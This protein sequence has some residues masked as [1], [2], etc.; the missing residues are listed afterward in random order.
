MLNSVKWNSIELRNKELHLLTF[1]KIIYNCVPND[2]QT[3]LRATRSKFV[4][5]QPRI[6]TYKFPMSL[7]FGMAYLIM[8]NHLTF[9]K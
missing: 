4:Q 1:Y 6:D 5:L 7:N 9:L 2:I 8:F 3:S